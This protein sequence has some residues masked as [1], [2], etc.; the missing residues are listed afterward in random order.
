MQ[1]TWYR[2]VSKWG[3]CL[4]FCQKASKVIKMRN[5]KTVSDSVCLGPEAA[6]SWVTQG[7][8]TQGQTP[9]ARHSPSKG[10]TGSQI[11]C[12]HSLPLTST[13]RLVEENHW[14]KKNLT[15]GQILRLDART[16]SLFRKKETKE[17]P[18]CNRSLFAWELS[19]PVK[20]VYVVAV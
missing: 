12:W 19:F 5:S 1:A 20:N 13:Q 2:R 17:M 4:C 8:G 7:S 10:H 16:V 9:P 18:F 14:E 3:G 11:R 15:W 6:V